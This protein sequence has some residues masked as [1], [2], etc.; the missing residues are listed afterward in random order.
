MLLV[1][2]ATLGCH[3]AVAA[4]P[5]NA[6]RNWCRNPPPPTEPPSVT[7]GRVI[8]SAL[9]ARQ[10]GQ[11]V[12]HF[13]RGDGAPWRPPTQVSAFVVRL[14]PFGADSSW[15]LLAAPLEPA[16]YQV[17]PLAAG[18]YHVSVDAFP[19]A[20]AVPLVRLTVRPGHTDTL[21]ALVWPVYIC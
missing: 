13:A 8:D 10:Q 15:S 18:T 14:G 16:W 21:R 4:A 20:S 9:H 6:P 11:V 2:L 19:A 12:V 17:P 1:L 7:S 5:S 3:P